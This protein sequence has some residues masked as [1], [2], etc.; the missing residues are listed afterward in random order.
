MVY[1]A[2]DRAA[3][4]VRCA[5]AAFEKWAA[6]RVAQAPRTQ[7]TGPHHLFSAVQLWAVGSTVCR[8][9][10]AEANFTVWFQ[11]EAEARAAL[12][13]GDA[14]AAV[15]AV[16]QLAVNSTREATARWQQLWQQLM[17]AT[18]DG[19]STTTNED[20]LLC[21]CAKEHPAF[22]D[23]WLRKVVVD[24]GERYIDPAG[25]APA[26]VEGRLADAALPIPKLDVPGVL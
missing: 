26:V 9:A 24:T 19:Y 12:A 23:A 25:A 21:G 11:A 14:S 1:A 18:A 4:I 10:R 6:A 17:V 5:R 3:P 16:T 20:D 22:S 7:T 15:A 8:C 2:Y 13:S